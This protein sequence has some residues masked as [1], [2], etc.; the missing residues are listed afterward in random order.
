MRKIHAKNFENINEKLDGLLNIFPNA[1]EFIKKII[2]GK[3]LY[4]KIRNAFRRL[5]HSVYKY[6]HS[7]NEQSEV[8]RKTHQTDIDTINEEFP[9]LAN[10]VILISKSGELFIGVALKMADFAVELS[11]IAKYT[12]ND[13]D[14]LQKKLQAHFNFWMRGSTDFVIYCYEAQETLLKQIISATEKIEAHLNEPNFKTTDLISGMKTVNYEINPSVNDNA[15][16]IAALDNDKDLQLQSY[17]KRKE[18]RRL[19]D[20]IN[21]EIDRTL[22]EI[23]EKVSVLLK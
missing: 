1:R 15:I 20:E 6:K 23:R 7:F 14:N 22:D 9:K 2:A 4:D 8:Y 18:K 16:K 12:R 3:E 21:N 5:R 17:Q 13:W 19:V 11:N 10:Q